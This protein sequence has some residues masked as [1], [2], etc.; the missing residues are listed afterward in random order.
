MRMKTFR[1]F[2]EFAHSV[3]DV[4]SKM[5]MRNPER[6]LWKIFNANGETREHRGV[7]FAGS[8]LLHVETGLVHSANAVHIS[9]SLA[10]SGQF[11]EQFAGGLQMQLPEH[12]NTPITQRWPGYPWSLLV[13][14]AA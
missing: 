1:D 4:D 7:H 9:D 2:D 6:H 13:E 10:Q 8:I 5:L 11:G 3:H 12:N 14:P